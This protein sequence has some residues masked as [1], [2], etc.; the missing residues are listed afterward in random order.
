MKKIILL[1]FLILSLLS[2]ATAQSR[3]DTIDIYN[4]VLKSVG[5]KKSKIVV[6]SM[7]DRS[8]FNNI[9]LAN[10]SYNT[11]D[12]TTLKFWHKKEWSDFLAKIDTSMLKNYVLKTNKKRLGANTKNS[13]GRILVSFSPIIFNDSNDK[14]LCILNYIGDGSGGAVVSAFFEKSNNIWVLNDILHL[15]LFD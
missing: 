2:I 13:K 9:H 4:K 8:L 3:P 5:L 12:T 7:T 10:P 15:V 14:A 6:K 1:S 11:L